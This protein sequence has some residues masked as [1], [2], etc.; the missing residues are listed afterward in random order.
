M[1]RW[2]DKAVAGSYLL[3][4]AVPTDDLHSPLNDVSDV[5]HLAAIG[6][7]DRLDVLRP[8]PARL[9]VRTA[10][11]HAADVHDLQLALAE[12][13]RFVGRVK[14]LLVSRSLLL[15]GGCICHRDLLAKRLVGD[16]PVATSSMRVIVLAIAGLSPS[17]P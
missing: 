17:L 8:L 7:R 6:L 13:A 9:M 14:A 11:G 4:R 3:L 10:D 2:D 15:G 5:V 1:S 12:R 16:R